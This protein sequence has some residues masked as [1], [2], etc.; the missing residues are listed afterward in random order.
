MRSLLHTIWLHYQQSP[1]AIVLE[2]YRGES[3][4]YEDLWQRACSY[5]HDLTALPTNEESEDHVAILLPKGI[6][7]IA[8][9]LGIW[10]AKKTAVV[11]DPQWPNQRIKNI[12]KEVEP[13]HIIKAEPT[14]IRVENIV[15]PPN[16]DLHSPAYII[17]S[18]GSSG[19]PKGVIVPHA[20]LMD[21][22]RDQIALFDLHPNSKSFWVHGIAFDA[23][24][25][26]I[27]T[28]LVAGATLC[29]DKCFTIKSSKH[30]LEQVTELHITHIDIPPSLLCVLDS[31][32]APECLETLIIG[33]EVTPIPII[34]EWAK[35][36]RLINVYGPTEATICTS[37]IRCDESWNSSD[38]GL[39]LNKV[40]Y[41]IIDP[42]TQQSATQGEL[43]ISG[44]HVALAY[45][46]QP[47]LTKDKF[48]IRGGKRVF[49]TGDLVR[50]KDSGSFEYLG[51][52]D[53]QIKISGKLFCPEEVEANLRSMEGVDEVFIAQTNNLTAWV[54][55]KSSSDELRQYLSE[56]LPQWM[57]PT[58][59]ISLTSFPKLSNGKLDITRL[60]QLKDKQTSQ[61]EVN[62]QSLENRLT[63]L[64]RNILGHQDFSSKDD[65][66]LNGGDSL[67]AIHF[68]LKAE[69][70]GIP[71]TPDSIH[72]YRSP[73]TIAAHI[74]TSTSYGTSNSKLS[75]RVLA[76]YESLSKQGYS[77]SSFAPSHSPEAY[78]ITGSTGF[79]GSAIIGN[80]LSQTVLPI[81]CLVRGDLAEKHSFL[82][83]KLEHHGF[84]ITEKQ[85]SRIEFIQA[86]VTE[87]RFGLALQDWEK[88][89]SISADI[90]HC[91]AEMNILQPYAELEKTNIQGALEII[92][93][94]LTSQYKRII[95]AST[96]SVFVDSYPTPAICIESDSLSKEERTIYGGYAQ[97]KWVADQ[98]LQTY[99]PDQTINLRLGL[100]TPNSAT[101]YAADND[102]FQWLIASLQ[103][104]QSEFNIQD[105]E[106]MDF[107]P[108]DFAAKA[109]AQI[110]LS[111]DTG[112]TY[113]I[114]NSESLRFSQIN[115]AIKVSQSNSSNDI[116][117]HGS[118]LID[119]A[120]SSHGRHHFSVNLFKT[121][122]TNFCT[123]NT[124][125]ILT[126]SN[127]HSPSLTDEFLKTYLSK[128][129][130]L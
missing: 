20:G 24:I 46:K 118:L 21:V 76:L 64:C 12:I 130:T 77:G 53:R 113:H 99:F 29:I 68:L 119:A 61:R 72:Q 96:L 74:E 73:K 106:S 1:Q 111:G 58:E 57:I 71:L 98:L 15:P 37:M 70:Q 65:F 95:Y 5:S 104:G 102:W 4:S 18:S 89:C 59:W 82:L 25:S 60:T 33:G 7:F 83:T 80:L 6:E 51:R 121:T 127:I 38:I 92:K 17:Y 50:R 66:F 124:D 78:I 81:I 52:I 42:F 97:T 122:H 88:L 11:I 40:S 8:A 109:I 110:M 62:P 22:F 30:F 75:Q 67:S 90:I 13:E 14:S 91:A 44:D 79:L 108:V 16:L 94:A 117:H 125:F 2:E 87:K 28:V 63:Q 31:S 39:P 35:K 114:A 56:S 3:Y 129:Y 85:S 55:S 120:N 115:S 107:T 36:L 43:Y 10:L 32:N 69:Q 48:S 105:D 9:L 23:S 41:D 34:R 103:N 84:N 86:D 47:Q 49:K 112:K 100:L 19:Q 101:G 128:L 54:I 123:K 93:L 27:G 126:G 45:L 26:D 116:S